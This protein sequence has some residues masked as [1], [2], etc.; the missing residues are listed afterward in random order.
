MLK[1]SKHEQYERSKVR[2]ASDG[3]IV[4]FEK[5]CGT[6]ASVKPISEFS[7]SKSHKSGINNRCK[8]CMAAY[9]AD[10]QKQARAK[11]EY[12]ERDKEDR[13][14]LKRKYGLTIPQ[15]DA[16]VAAQGGACAICRQAE[17]K[18]YRGRVMRLQVDHCHTTGK[19]R[20]LLCRACNSGMGLMRD[21]AARL[22]TAA[23][24]LEKHKE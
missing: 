24:Y 12:K 10:W 14:D 1:S 7:P 5:P 8:K 2:G 15:Y 9:K 21:D 11:D 13:Y 22:R 4:A 17:D 16:L 18:V 6:C 3:L 20:G 23:E 19:V